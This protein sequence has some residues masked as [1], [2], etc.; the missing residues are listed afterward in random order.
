MSNVKYRCRDDYVFLSCPE[1]MVEFISILA[2]NQNHNTMHVIRMNKSPLVS[3][4]SPTQGLTVVEL[5]VVISILGILIASVVGSSYNSL[6]S[7]RNIERTNDISAISRSLEQYY[8]TQSVA[9][10]ATYPS[11]STTAASLAVIVGDDD[12]VTAPDET[13]NSI[14][15]ASSN[16]AQA[17]AFSQY[18]YQALRADG[19]LC[20]ALPCSRYK[21]Y[22]HL[23]TTDDVVVKNS[24]RQQ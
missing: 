19:T 17:P 12:I 14:I 15:V 5:V 24:L 11:S 6:A 9:T 10:G 2:Y 22:Y 16:S 21:L 8:R 23:E 7:G 1:I 18:A 4:H 20:T 13:S 3:M